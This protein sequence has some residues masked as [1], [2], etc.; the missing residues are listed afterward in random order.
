MAGR[1]IDRLCS[2]VGRGNVRGT[3]VWQGAFSSREAEI[4][5][6]AQ[7]LL[8]CMIISSN[9]ASESIASGDA[10][11]SASAQVNTAMRMRLLTLTP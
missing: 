4:A 2:A 8:S 1:L 3:R 5:R 10:L 7:Q 6:T 11:L 9:I